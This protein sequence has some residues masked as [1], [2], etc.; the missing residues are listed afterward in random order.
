MPAPDDMIYMYNQ[1]RII[2]ILGFLLMAIIVKCYSR[3]HEESRMVMYP[4]GKPNL[5]KDGSSV[6]I[7]CVVPKRLHKPHIEVW[8][9]KRE[10]I[11]A[12]GCNAI[13]KS[14]RSNCRKNPYAIDVVK[15]RFTVEDAGLY[16]CSYGGLHEETT[17][18]I[19]ALTWTISPLR[20]IKYNNK[21]HGECSQT[22]S[23]NYNKHK[24]IIYHPRTE[25]EDEKQI[26]YGC[27][28]SPDSGY[29]AEIVSC[30]KDM[31]KVRIVVSNVTENI[32]LCCELMDQKKCLDVTTVFNHTDVYVPRG[33]DYGRQVSGKSYSYRIPKDQ[34]GEVNYLNL[35]PLLA[36]IIFLVISAVYIIYWIRSDR[37]KKEP[38]GKDCMVN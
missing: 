35:I 11:I 31:N 5:V 12:R 38:Q 27:D 9:R 34:Q 7:E 17:F 21:I 13:D 29:S 37:K 28:V 22:T 19:D 16:I 33:P 10:Q 14:W 36:F 30:S 23:V 2:S 18:S 15:N 32:T 3:N 4:M 24:I 8:L 6:R 25:Y 1:K 26:S 20:V